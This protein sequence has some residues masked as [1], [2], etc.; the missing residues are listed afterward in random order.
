MALPSIPSDDGTAAAETGGTSR[1]WAA[2]WGLAT[3]LVALLGL[4]LVWAAGSGRE[5]V[6]RLAATTLATTLGFALTLWRAG[7]LGW[8]WCRRGE[9]T[10]LA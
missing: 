8:C 7:L 4:R 10:G 9:R 6:Q 2:A 3:A 1:W 5:A